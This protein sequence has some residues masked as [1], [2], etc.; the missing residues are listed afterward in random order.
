MLSH[1]GNQENV[2]L[3]QMKKKRKTRGMFSNTNIPV[4]FQPKNILRLVNPKE[5]MPKHMLSSV[6]YAAQCN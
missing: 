2:Q 3:N 5:K 4:Y 1:L 6:V